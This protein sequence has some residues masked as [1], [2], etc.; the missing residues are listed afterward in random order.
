[1]PNAAPRPPPATLGAV[2]G[3]LA[4]ALFGASAPLAKTLLPETSPLM[5][6]GLLY[7]GGGLGLAAFGALRGR[8][9]TAREAPLRRADAGTLVAII[10]AGGIGGP[11]LMLHGLA[12]L[13]GVVASLLLNLEAPFTIGLALLVFRE[14]LGRRELGAA[15]LVVL[16]A[17]VLGV[18]PG[19]LA[20]DPL[21]VLALAGACLCWA[22]DNNLTQRL[23][24]R[25]PVAVVRTKA[26]GAGGAMLG[27][28][29]LLRVPL[30][31]A[32]V[33]VLALALGML[34]YGLSIVLD[35]YALRLLGAAREA[36]FFATAPFLG[37]LL[38]VPL[39][40]ERPSVPDG[41]AAL[42]MA[43]GVALLLRE[44]HGHPHTHEPAEHEH[45]HVHDEHHR[46]L[47]EGPA[48]EPHSHPHR[49]VEL[50]HDHPHVSDLHHR[51]GHR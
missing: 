43:A 34:S 5:L 3:L 47:H 33:T 22:L 20:A 42:A 39:L 50:T 13:P 32:L 21:G 31:S 44:R 9:R 18:S 49:H 2:Y 24:L 28:A 51:H 35:M 26:L 4:A 37:A 10:L 40:G 36:A 45:L 19:P 1:M 46:H 27:T 41:L 23:S 38:A 29:L 48:V 25:D 15:G 16:G 30:P 6:G 17:A 7:L 11:L 12:R 8:T 14:H